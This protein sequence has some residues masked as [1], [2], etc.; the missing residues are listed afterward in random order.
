MS[1][2]VNLGVLLVKPAHRITL[3]LRYM[4]LLNLADVNVYSAPCTPTLSYYIPIWARTCKTPV[5]NLEGA[6]RTVLKVIIRNRTDIR[7]SGS[8]YNA[9]VL[10]VSTLALYI[11]PE[12]RISVFSYA[13]I[14]L[15]KCSS[16]ADPHFVSFVCS[17]QIIFLSFENT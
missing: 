9:R 7:P 13:Y 6:H 3:S 10:S 17:I 15:V 12:G 16:A 4:K 2:C 11:E 14:L 8:I 1:E 5:L